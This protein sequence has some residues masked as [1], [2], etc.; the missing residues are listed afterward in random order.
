MSEPSMFI[1]QSP[2]EVDLNRN[3]VIE[4]HAGTGKTYTIVQL[5]LRL[6]RGESNHGRAPLHIRHLL[7]VTYTDKAAGELK[8][9]IREG[10]VSAINEAS[11][12]NEILLAAHLSDCLNN[13]HEA[14]IGTIH[15]VSLRILRA[16]PF[17]TG[18][19]FQTTQCSDADGLQDAFY[20]VIR[21]QW[22]EPESPDAKILKLLQDSGVEFTEKHQGLVLKL[23]KELLNDVTATLDESVLHG[24]TDSS[25]YWERKDLVQKNILDDV[26][27]EYKKIYPHWKHWLTRLLTLP[28][29]DDVSRDL[30]QLKLDTL[31]QLF[32]VQDFSSPE[33]SDVKNAG[34]R[35]FIDGR[36]AYGKANKELHSQYCD[37]MAT[38]L[39]APQKKSALAFTLRDEPYKI[40]LTALI[41]GTAQ[42]VA[43]RWQTIKAESGLISFQDMLRFTYKA[44][45]GNPSLVE[46]LRERLHYGIID[47]FQDTSALQWNVFERIFLA[48]SRTN[49]S[50][51]FIVGDPK[52]SIYAFQGADVG[53]Y[54]IAKEAIL[55]KGGKL[56]GLI[57]N[58][59]SLPDVI[60]GYNRI[61]ARQE[62]STSM[63]WFL[64]NSIAYPGTGSGARIAIPPP[65]KDSAQPLQF[66][67]VQVVPLD[68]NASY[69]RKTFA[70]HIS[71]IIRA[72]VGRPV[73][74]PKGAQWES[75]TLQYH[76]FAVIV[77]SH[78]AA[79]P[80]LSKLSEDGIP[81]VKYKLPG[82][83]QS[84][85]CQ[86]VNA[87]L[88]ALRSTDS[89]SSVRL[90]ALLTS[91]FHLPPIS[92]QPE[93]M[94]EPDSAPMKM[95]SAWSETAS[96]RR[97]GQLFA[98]ILHD[99]QIETRLVRLSD[100]ERQ[101]CDLRQVIDHCIEY[102]VQRNWTLTDLTEHLDQLLTEEQGGDEEANLHSLATANSAVHVL[103]M[104]ASK[105][106]EYPIVFVVP[107][108]SEDS[109]KRPRILRWN[110]EDGKLH[111]VPDTDLWNLSVPESETQ[112][113]QERRRKLYVA[114]T[115]PQLALFV[116]MVL[117]DL[118]QDENGSWDW[119]KASTLSSGKGCEADLSPRLLDLLRAQQVTPFDAEVWDAMP[120]LDPTSPVDSLDPTWSPAKNPALQDQMT[121]LSAQIE[122]LKL[123]ARRSL[124]TSYT[125]LSHDL[126][127][128]RELSSSEE[129]SEPEVYEESALPRGKDTGDALHN[130]LEQCIESPTWKEIPLRK[131]LQEE[132]ANN[133]VLSKLPDE[134]SRSLAL[135]AAERMVRFALECPYDMGPWG[136]VSLAELKFNAELG[137]CRAELEFQLAHKLPTTQHPDWL[138]G[139]MDVVFRM[140]DPANPVHPWRYH[141]LDWKTNSLPL[142]DRSHI[143][144]SIVAS[145]Y[146]LQ[147][148][149]YAHALHEFLAGLLGSTY[150]PEAN[151][152][153]AV[154]VYLR[155][156]EKHD[157]VDVWC[158][159]G[160]PLA[161]AAFVSERI[162][163]WKKGKQ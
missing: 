163:A 76:D 20:H 83:F 80:F 100:G 105:G 95:L 37:E 106:L 151:L 154:Y 103:T 17:D 110:A 85:L 138:H 119:E 96:H 130:V 122:D 11:G 134:A 109:S 114:L 1:L 48:D 72:L 135:D 147:A 54:E 156:F 21:T 145:H 117:K 50:R 79:E 104:H 155:A 63:D 121:R 42:S 36:N 162:E 140:R 144:S 107:T 120:K 62:N 101:L 52:Q 67:P 33:W 118:P 10:L 28:K 35:K 3:G 129:W 70:S 146:D 92:L 136:K 99:S 30:L 160:N 5:V 111:L 4:A 113:R 38:L 13:M 2:G 56:Y 75:R 124:Q 98:E 58:Y 59:R 55:R 93:K 108:S 137:S 22:Q 161:D 87:L 66:H 40:G 102:L 91:F 158:H 152:G 159:D 8:T 150:N 61:L 65:R 157:T 132:L 49:P 26:G 153:T 60:H 14:M 43:T 44:V 84:S 9:R 82:V 23:A 73:M 12:A 88:K 18:V 126:E 115:R 142:Y 19:Q 24:F 97:W 86:Q 7:L 32:H 29:L 77:E 34:G 71:T 64:H 6:L 74:I 15:S 127:N 94:L 81:A 143:E 51:I 139:F 16:W 125:E 141:V 69:R 78:S 148:K 57:N 131:R 149:V 41:A 27:E 89:D 45:L 116:P 128:A 123:T 133:N 90:S 46:Q 39:E 112:R 68:G 25:A 47:E 53:S 31:S